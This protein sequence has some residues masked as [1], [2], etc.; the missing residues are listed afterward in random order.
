MQN[1]KNRFQQNMTCVDVIVPFSLLL[2]PSYNVV[3][4]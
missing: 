2:A 3:S 1:T 4:L